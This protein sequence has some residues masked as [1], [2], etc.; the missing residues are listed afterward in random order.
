MVPVYA[1][2]SA[3]KNLTLPQ[4]SPQ[5]TFSCLVHGDSGGGW[6][7]LLQP[8]PGVCPLTIFSHGLPGLCRSRPTF[9]SNPLPF[10]PGSHSQ[11]ASFSHGPQWLY[12]MRTYQLSPV[13]P[14]WNIWPQRA[15]AYISCQA[16]SRLLLRDT[17]P[18][19]PGERT[20]LHKYKVLSI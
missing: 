16:S 19:L 17:C 12:H 2:V 8:S 7:P 10:V 3:D 11:Y 6:S 15:A 20:L 5:C 1:T 13:F 14:A 4:G 9:R 18:E